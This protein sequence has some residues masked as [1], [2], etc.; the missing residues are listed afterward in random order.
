MPQVAVIIV[1]YQCAAILPPTLAALRNQTVAPDRILLVDNGSGDI[2]SLRELL[3]QYPEVELLALEE[4]TGFARANNLGFARCDG[5]EFVTC[6]NPDAR[7]QPD[8][9]A[10]LLSAAQRHPAYSAFGSRRLQ[11]AEEMRL[12]GAG[13]F[14]TIAG[15][16]GRRGYG[17]RASP[18]FEQPGP[19]FSPCAAA[20]LYRLD[21]IKQVGGF[22]ESFFCY[23]EDVDLGFRLLLRGHPSYYVPDSVVC[24]IG[25]AVTGRRSD[26]SVYHGQRNLV[27]N[28]VKN[29]PWPL[30][31]AFLPAHLLLNTCYVVGSILIGRGRVVIHAKRDALAALPGAWRA[32]REVQKSRATSSW[33]VMQK[34]RWRLW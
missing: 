6:L 16:P 19:I 33:Q 22:D 24:H 31:W 18:Q 30:L 15:K 11:D 17:K 2:E 9:L 26:F 25:S 3:R 32:R 34:L 13:D 28:Y 27:I 5:F 23:V 10:A 14:L 8:W 29:M 12:D 21:A 7:P 4:N 20:A 1:S